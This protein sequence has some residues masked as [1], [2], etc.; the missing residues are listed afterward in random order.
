M[1]RITKEV[2]NAQAEML[3]RYTNRREGERYYVGYEN[4]Y[5]N[6]FTEYGSGRQTVSYGNT[7]KELS[8][9]LSACI[10]IL[11][12]EEARQRR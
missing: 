4:G 12:L 11:S 3:N 7:K 9:Q 6:L 8:E 1:G 2:L 10:K 5:A